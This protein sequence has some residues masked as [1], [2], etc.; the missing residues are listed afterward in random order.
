MDLSQQN[1]II[2]VQ[3]AYHQQTPVDVRVADATQPAFA[4]TGGIE[5]SA[6]VSKDDQT[7]S[8]NIYQ[9]HQ[10]NKNGLYVIDLK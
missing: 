6:P 7:F 5:I 10:G 9:F 8:S 4:K 3:K 1:G 2:P